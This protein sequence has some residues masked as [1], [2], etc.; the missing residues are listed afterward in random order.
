MRP[1]SRRLPTLVLALSLAAGC[2]TGTSSRA[3]TTSP[4]L[5][6]AAL[7]SRYD[8]AHDLGP[9]FQDVQVSE[10]FPDSKTFAAARPRR[11]PGEIVAAYAAARGAAGFSLRAFV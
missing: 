3:A 2:T 11:P 10:I 8:P 4:V 1:F 6:R 9:L 5:A 7:V